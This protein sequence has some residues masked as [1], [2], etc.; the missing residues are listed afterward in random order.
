MNPFPEGTRVF[1]WTSSG[2]CEYAIVQSSARLA[3]GTLILSLKVE[4]KDKVATIPAA[5][6]TKVT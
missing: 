6:V 1:Y 3:D 4:G 5:G 2:T